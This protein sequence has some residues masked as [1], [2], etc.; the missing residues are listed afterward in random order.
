MFLCFIS[1]LIGK[2]VAYSSVAS[3]K[4]G[5]ST[6]LDLMKPKPREK[7]WTRGP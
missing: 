7:S 6:G 4:L 1:L 5:G 3:P 2:A